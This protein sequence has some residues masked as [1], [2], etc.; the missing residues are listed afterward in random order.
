MSSRQNL[1]G[2]AAAKSKQK[3]GGLRKFVNK[4]LSSSFGFLMRGKFVRENFRSFMNGYMCVL[5][6][7]RVVI[8]CRNL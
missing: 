7:S 3:E 6:L 5:V 2:F 1:W 4:N 8:Y